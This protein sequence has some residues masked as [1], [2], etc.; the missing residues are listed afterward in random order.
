M[1]FALEMMPCGND[2]NSDLPT[3]KVVVTESPA[4]VMA[5]VMV[6]RLQSL[7]LKTVVEQYFI[8]QIHQLLVSSLI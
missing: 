1:I 6:M 2:S 5:N 3:L 7:V 4:V 8:I